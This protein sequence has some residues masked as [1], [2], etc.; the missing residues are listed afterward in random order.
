MIA[1]SSH[2]GTIVSDNESFP[3]IWDEEIR[4][5]MQSIA[6]TEGIIFTVQTIIDHSKLHKQAIGFHVLKC[7]NPQS[8]LDI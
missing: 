6:D 4:S 5:H 7:E 2:R 3:V 8:E 1:F